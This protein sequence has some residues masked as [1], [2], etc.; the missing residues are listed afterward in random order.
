MKL[1][2]RGVLVGGIAY[3][4]LQELPDCLVWYVSRN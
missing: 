3:E 2:V 4:I 1:S